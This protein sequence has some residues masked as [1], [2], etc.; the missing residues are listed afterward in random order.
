MEDHHPNGTQ[1]FGVQWC[2]RKRHD[3]VY[4]IFPEKCKIRFSRFRAPDEEVRRLPF[5]ANP[6][7]YDSRISQISLNFLY[8]SR[9]RWSTCRPEGPRPSEFAN[10]WRSILNEEEEFSHARKRRSWDIISGVNSR[11]HP[12][13]PIPAS[14]HSKIQLKLCATPTP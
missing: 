2:L 7:L 4:A 12:G 9:I 8:R 13:L 5:S 10:R 3:G 14:F 11:L 1:R 6:S